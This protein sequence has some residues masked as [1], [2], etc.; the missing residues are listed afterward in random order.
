M[1]VV[2]YAV[3]TFLKPIAGVVLM[4]PVSA[5]DEDYAIR[6]LMIAEDQKR[7][8]ISSS[9]FVPT[10]DFCSSGETSFQP[11]TSLIGMA[12]PVVVRAVNSRSEPYIA[13]IISQ[14]AVIS[15]MV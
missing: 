1:R 12:T 9:N 15:S 6:A 4:Q 7:R 5:E 3:K 8:R 10:K 11:D 14:S 13:S 2:T